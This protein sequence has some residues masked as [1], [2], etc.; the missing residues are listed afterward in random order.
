MDAKQKL[1][2]T[3]RLLA[4]LEELLPDFLEATSDITPPTVEG[5]KG[6]QQKRQEVRSIMQDILSR[7]RDLQWSTDCMPAAEKGRKGPP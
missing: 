1:K 2:K 3:L 7:S 4:E 6:L 5:Q